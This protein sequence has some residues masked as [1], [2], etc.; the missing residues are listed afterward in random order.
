MAPIDVFKMMQKVGLLE[1]ILHGQW[2]YYRRNEEFI[3]QI[4]DYFRTETL[5]I[6]ISVF[7]LYYIYFSR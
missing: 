3:Q 7:L 1:S 2:T 5:L 6:L 4:G